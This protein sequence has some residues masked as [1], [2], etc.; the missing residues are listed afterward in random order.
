MKTSTNTLQKNPPAVVTIAQSVNNSER[1]VLVTSETILKA[2]IFQTV[3][4]TS[5]I[6]VML[7]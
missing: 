6:S 2:N 7:F 1:E 3:S 5:A 4:T